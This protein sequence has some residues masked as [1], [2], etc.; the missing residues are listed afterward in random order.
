MFLRGFQI[1]FL[2]WNMHQFMLDH[3]PLLSVLQDKC[4]VIDIRLS[5]FYFFSVKKAFC[6]R[7]KPYQ[8]RQ[9]INYQWQKNHIKKHIF[10]Y[11]FGFHY[12]I[13]FK[14]MFW[15]RF[16]FYFYFCIQLFFFNSKIIYQ[17]DLWGKFIDF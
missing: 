4:H 16:Y 8:K 3:T 2:S 12:L 6:S 9:R 5:V 15:W 10:I 1:I 17:A 14:L 13:L 7:V 11:I